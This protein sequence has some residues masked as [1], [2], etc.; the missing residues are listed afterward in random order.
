MD[1]GSLCLG[2]VKLGDPKYGFS[3]QSTG[4]GGSPISFLREAARMGIRRYDTSPRYGRSEAVLGRFLATESG[5]FVISS[6]IDG[7]VPGDPS[8]PLKM[9]KSVRRSLERLHVERLDICYLHQDNLTIISDPYVGEGLEQLQAEGLIHLTGASLYEPSQCEY[10]IESRRFDI[11]QLPIN[12][13]DT[14]LYSRFVREDSS[15]AFCA[16]SLLLQGALVNRTAIPTAIRH[17][18]EVLDYLSKLDV[19]A[20]RSKMSTLAMALAFVFGLPGI[21]HFLIGTTSV[22]S[23]KENVSCQS[24][25]LSAGIRAELSL[26]AQS[27]KVWANPRNW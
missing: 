4:G 10:A 8:T 9:R 6:K 24:V 13:C 15:C 16:R 1:T 5:E 2:T 22:A 25:S 20:R 27:P 23:L 19:L 3:S 17:S 11:V 26:L 18:T 14:S 7:L 21:E 12:V